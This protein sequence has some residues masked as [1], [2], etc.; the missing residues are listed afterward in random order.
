MIME[1]DTPFGGGSMYSTIGDLLRW[2]QALYSNRLVSKESLAQI[3]TPYQGP[4]VPTQAWQRGLYSRHRWGYGWWITRWFGRDLVWSSGFIHGFVAVML[5]YTQDRTL[6]IVLE[7]MEPNA[8]GVTDPD[9]QMEPMTLA[10]GLSAIAF[11][12]P[13]GANP[14]SVTVSD[15][16]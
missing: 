6:V 4:Y 14:V 5:R 13:P 10:N 1:M 2:D 9:L 8:E 7:N 16:K 11:G 15:I 12:L 3:F